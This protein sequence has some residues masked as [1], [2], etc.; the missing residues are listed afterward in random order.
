MVQKPSKVIGIKSLVAGVLLLILGGFIGTFTIH[1][2]NAQKD[3]AVAKTLSLAEQIQVAC[4]EGTDAE[5]INN[6]DL[7]KEATDV[8][9]NPD[10]VARGA[11]GDTGSMG[12]Q[13]PR[14]NP[15]DP[16]PRGPIGP[17]GPKGDTGEQGLLGALGNTGAQ[18]E[19]GLN[20]SPGIQGPKGDKG[21]RGDQGI[22]GEPGA[23]G[24]KGDPGTPPV[25]SIEGFVCQG[26]DLILT[27]NGQTAVAAGAC[28]DTQIAPAP[29]A[30]IPV[31]VPE[32]SGAS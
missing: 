4:I 13:G 2:A 8:I 5:T 25:I 15:G 30:P 6:Y 29:V 17:I 14:G 16:G 12:A 22:Q 18:G 11:K 7:C 27:I 24:D 1:T 31:P 21:D 23:K 26:D 3:T 32:P 20:G 28:R 10:Q 19:P 9:D